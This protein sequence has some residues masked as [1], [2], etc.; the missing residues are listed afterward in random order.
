MSARERQLR[1]AL[2]R[3]RRLRAAQVGDWPTMP[4]IPTQ[5]DVEAAAIGPVLLTV[6][7]VWA[8]ANGV[9]RLGSR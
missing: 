1:A 7:G 8:L 3:V 2:A 9:D 4:R 6:I 5:R